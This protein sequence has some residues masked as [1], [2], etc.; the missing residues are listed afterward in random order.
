MPFHHGFSGKTVPG[1]L[2]LFILSVSVNFISE[3]SPGGINT[4]NGWYAVITR[5]YGV[6]AAEIEKTIT[7]PVEDAIYGLSGIKEVKASS[8]FSASRVDIRLSDSADTDKFLLKL[9]EQVDMCYSDIINRCPAVQKPQIFSSGSEQNAVFSAAFSCSTKSPEELRS[10]IEDEIKPSFL[11]ISGVGEIEVYGGS[12]TEI[13]IAADTEVAA[14]F[15]YRCGDIASLIRDSNLYG[16]AGSLDSGLICVPV[17]FDARLTSIEDIKNLPAGPVGKLSEIADISYSSRIPENNSRFNSRQLISISIKSSASDL[18][19]LSRELRA[20]T[21]KWKNTGYQIEVINDRGAEL[22][23]SFIRIT[24]AL[25]AGIILSAAVLFLFRI[26]LRRILIL[27]LTQPVILIVSLGVLTA[28]GIHPDHYIIAGLS[29]GSGLIL[30]SALLITDAIETGKGRFIHVLKPLISSTVT[31]LIALL[32]VMTLKQEIQGSGFITLSLAVMLIVSLVFSVIFI[33]PFY[34]GRTFKLPVPSGKKFITKAF[35][36]NSR[37]KLAAAGL[38]ISAGI[39]SF[40]TLPISLNEPEQSP[41]VFAKIE[42]PRGENIISSDRKIKSLCD[43]L[44]SKD[45]I[46]DI[47]STAGRGGGRITV[48]YDKH[49]ADRDTVISEIKSSGEM[50]PDGFIF[51]PDECTADELK[52]K[53][54]VSG[55][56]PEKLRLIAKDSLKNILMNDWASGGV[57]HFGEKAPAYQYIPDRKSHAAAGLSVYETASFLRWNLQG[58]VAD[59][60]QLSGKEMDLRIMAANNSDLSVK[61]LEALKIADRSGEAFRRLDHLGRFIETEEPDRLNRINRQ[62]SESFTVSCRST[63]PEKL[64]KLIWNELEKTELPPGY[65]F[66]PSDKLLEKKALYSK[67]WLQLFFAIIMIYILLAVERESLFQPLL[68]IIQLPVILSV[69]IITVRIMSVPIGTETIL[70]LILISGMGINNGIL[71]MENLK[72]GTKAAVKS[73]FNSLVLTTATSICGILPM[74]FTG[75]PFFTRLAVILISGLS[76]SFLTA[77]FI[78][79]PVLDLSLKKGCTIDNQFFS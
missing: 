58:P 3:T 5:Y 43:R 10:F 78:L 75:V 20:E 77:V 8:E 18:I 39:I 71:I 61:D 28:A 37:L 52:L 72:Y 31:T 44:Q 27:S 64:Q 48:R 67:M 13:H 74:L 16:T 55:P 60:R 57:L 34:Q 2:I 32:P 4:E 22:E 45:F 76:A 69:P 15:G 70:G 12:L 19:R 36:L 73:R 35:L 79:P 1:F 66:L 7:I 49:L 14:A 59:K 38:I 23:E 17:S 51:L 63:D 21:E 53:I 65:T 42:L 11:K 41:V 50:L 30:D 9:R 26:N 47:H 33:P 68:I 62:H 24:A 6:T 54:T 40:I 29:V 56:D 25:A 46:K